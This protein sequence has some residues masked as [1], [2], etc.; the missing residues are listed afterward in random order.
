MVRTTGV[1]RSRVINRARGR[2]AKGRRARARVMRCAKLTMIKMQ[3][4]K[5]RASCF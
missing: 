1:R 4:A 5:N 3:K 2:R